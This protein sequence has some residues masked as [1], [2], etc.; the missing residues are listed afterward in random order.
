MTT[1]FSVA[2]LSNE[3]DALDKM[4]QDSATAEGVKPA[5]SS[6]GCDAPVSVSGITP[7]SIGPPGAPPKPP[8]QQKPPP[9]AR[10]PD[11]IWDS[12]EVRDTGDEEDDPNDARPEPEVQRARRRPP[13]ASLT[14]RAPLAVLDRI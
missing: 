4:F 9:K 14:P 6:Y 8:Q 1:D 2:S 7:G 11:A 13:G 10:D 12:A 3:F 5:P